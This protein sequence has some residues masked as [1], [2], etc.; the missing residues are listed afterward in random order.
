MF[1]IERL[2]QID[3]R[4][5]VHPLFHPTDHT[6]P[7]IWV[8]GHGAMIRGADGREFIDGLSGLWN[9]NV[10]HGRAEL[11]EAAARQMTKLAY[12]SAYT[13]TT[14][15]PAIKLAE[16]LAGRCYPSINHFFFTSG[17]A[18]SND[19]AFK[20][21]R[22]YW[23]AKGKP[24]KLKIISLNLGYHGVTLGAMNATGLEMYRP[25][26]GPPMP[27][28]LRIPP[29]YPYRF[30][31]TGSA[32]DPGVAA[33]N[34]LEE[35]ILREGPETIAAFIAE[36]VQGVGGAIVPQD[37]YFP[38]IR[39]ICDTYDVLLI[40]D[41]V[42]TGF[43]RTGK[44]FALEHWGVEPDIVSMAKGI[45]SAYVPLGGIGL[46]DRVFSCLTEVSPENRWMHAY[47]YSGH[48]TCSA[49]A[50]ENIAIL[51]REGLVEAS[52]E[53]G[54]RLLDGLGQLA[55][56]DHVGD[57]RGL[58]LMTGVELVEDKATKRSFA[59][60]RKVGAK[61]HAEC[62]RRG[63]FSRFRSDIYVIAP[64]FVTENDDIDRIV[65][66]LGESIPVAVTSD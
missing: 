54:K 20:T 46:S 2:I 40:A 59:P 28:F 30:E 12:A 39:E 7:M 6:D 9:V 10:G 24:D 52:A 50:L 22:F 4:H 55:A 32:S 25:G 29:P 65:N 5:L 57:V 60:E 26:F 53:K 49:V 3:Q 1:D 31:A 58:G 35:A 33:A 41:E 44:W 45:T 66:I 36:P 56:L 23:N 11:G 37:S 13:G 21:S 43:G 34:G 27:G 17:G 15:I 61:L 42:I 64:P 8:E 48:P 62:V 14:N 38:R 47:T 19:S 63:L 18:E 16:K 51:E